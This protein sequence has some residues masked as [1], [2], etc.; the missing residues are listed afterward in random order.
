MMKLH[1]KEESMH[2]AVFGI[3]ETLL[4]IHNLIEYIAAVNKGEQPSAAGTN[5]IRN[6][7]IQGKLL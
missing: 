1:I 2:P 5:L 4:G 6:V 7:L 3:K